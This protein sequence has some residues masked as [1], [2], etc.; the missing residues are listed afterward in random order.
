MKKYRH[1]LTATDF[2][3]VSKVAAQQAIDLAE[4]YEAELTFLHVVEHFPEHLPHY[5]IA[6][7]DKDPQEFL[8]DKADNDLAEMCRGLGHAEA[9]REVIL[10]THSAKVEI[11]NYIEAHNIELLV[12]GA[13]GR[14]SLID[15]FSG[16]TA[17]GVVRAAVC[18][19]FVVHAGE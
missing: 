12:I 10:T 17:T 4:H 9:R 15:R 19:V 2:S 6:H 16:S 13:R 18:D 1:I 7:E 8:I 3:A 14:H 11:V 5:K